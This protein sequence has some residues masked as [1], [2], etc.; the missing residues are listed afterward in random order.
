MI[1]QMPNIMEKVLRSSGIAYSITSRAQRFIKQNAAMLCLG[2]G[3][4]NILIT[5]ITLNITFNNSQRL[6][7]NE[8]SQ[9]SWDK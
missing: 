7:N 8:N 2:S 6:G 9:I 5:C 1:N 4:I 3:S